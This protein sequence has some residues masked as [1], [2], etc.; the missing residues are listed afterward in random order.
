VAELKVVSLELEHSGMMAGLRMM[1]ADK[2]M[3]RV[4]LEVAE[5]HQT[6]WDEAGHMRL[7][8]VPEH[9]ERLLVAHPKVATSF[10]EGLEADPLAEVGE[11]VLIVARIQVTTRVVGHG[12]V[13]VGLGR[14]M[15]HGSEE[16][17]DVK[18]AWVDQSLAYHSRP[19]YDLC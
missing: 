18:L 11:L 2:A 14:E 13:V 15:P 5:E 1:V 4:E 9:T 19:E 10:V 7:F 17:R 12:T 6:Q 3:L 8:G 16:Y